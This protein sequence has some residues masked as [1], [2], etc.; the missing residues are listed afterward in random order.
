MRLSLLPALLASTIALASVVAQQPQMTTWRG[1]L[2]AQGTKLRLELDITERADEL[3]GEMR[4]LD[5]GN[6]KLK[7]SDIKSDA[8]TLSFSIRTIGA[9]FSGKVAEDGRVAQGTFSQSGMNLPLT[10]TKSDTRPSWRRRNRKRR[11]KKPG[12]VS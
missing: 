9:T 10:L 2:D 5:Q 11:C 6:T 4:S 1:T 12:S 7:A 8:E 3:V